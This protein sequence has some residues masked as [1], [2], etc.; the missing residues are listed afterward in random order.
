MRS[1]VL[2]ILLLGAICLGGGIFVLQLDIGSQRGPFDVDAVLS[3]IQAELNAEI[4]STSAE[5]QAFCENPDLVIEGAPRACGSHN[6]PTAEA[7]GIVDR[8]MNN[9][10][11]SAVTDWRTL[12]GWDSRVWSLTKDH[13]D[14][15]DVMLTNDLVLIY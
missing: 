9:T 3:E 8:I 12:S 5:V 1:G 6:T 14:S 15:L 4:P 7:Q 10:S 2:Y 13:S 11:A